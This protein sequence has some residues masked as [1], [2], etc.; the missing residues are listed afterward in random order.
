MDKSRETWKEAS[1]KVVDKMS[2]G[3]LA[4]LDAFQTF[5]V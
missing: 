3:F 2:K 5:V 1:P 4:F